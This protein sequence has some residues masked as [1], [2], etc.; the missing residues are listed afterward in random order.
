MLLFNKAERS[1]QK[2]QK[3]SLVKEGRL[4]ITNKLYKQF[5]REDKVAKQA[6]DNTRKHN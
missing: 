1:K 4:F 2:K 6:E 5:C 3:S